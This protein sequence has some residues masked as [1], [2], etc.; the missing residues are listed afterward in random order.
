MLML[1]SIL[2]FEESESVINFFE[3]Q[4]GRQLPDV[5]S[6]AIVKQNPISQMIPVLQETAQYTLM[7]IIF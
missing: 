1:A 6:F 5:L 2:V 4:S 3:H 7:W